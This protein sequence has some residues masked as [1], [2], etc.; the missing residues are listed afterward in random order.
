M[1]RLLY[2][3][4]AA[5][6]LTVPAAAA[7][8]GGLIVFSRDFGDEDRELFSIRPDGSGLTR[9][10]D[11]DLE[12]AEPVLSPDRRLIAAASEDELVVRTV[13]GRLLHRIEVPAEGTIAEPRWSPRGRLIAFLLEGCET[14]DEAFPRSSCADLWVARPDGGPRR[15]VAAS[16]ST[17]DLVAAYAWSP[18]GRSLVY[19]RLGKP[20]LVVVDVVTRRTR[21]LRGT[22]QFGSSDPSWSRTGRIAFARRRGPL[23]GYDVYAVRSDGRGLRR[24]ARGGSVARPT[25]SP[26]GRRIAFLDFNPNAALNRW[27]VTVV[28]ADGSDRRRIGVAT[29]EL[30]LAWSPDGT[31][32]LWQNAGN[33]IVVGRADGRGRPRLLARGSVADW[34]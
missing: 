2:A 18:G 25:W 24:I 27:R 7:A 12:E 19:E 5:C 9:L 26:N 29:T 28:R 3:L 16:V 8:P 32:L 6:A 10:T 23:A 20:G 21:V 4:A 11:D 14:D 1:R 31:R 15:L 17:N 22:T 13:S 33:R 30:T 34:R